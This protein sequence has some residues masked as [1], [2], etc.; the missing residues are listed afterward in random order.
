MGF[1]GLG[2]G[3]EGFRVLGFRVW[4]VWGCGVG[5]VEDLGLR[6]VRFRGL[7]WGVKLWG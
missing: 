3:A 5:S 1:R 2:F 4:G 7:F 6:L